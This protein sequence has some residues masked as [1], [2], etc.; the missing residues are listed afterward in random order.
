VA[1]LIQFATV[2]EVC[3]CARAAFHK[4]EANNARQH[5]P[6]KSGTSPRGSDETLGSNSRNEGI[7]KA[8]VT[9][10]AAMSGK[11]RKIK[12]RSDQRR[13]ESRFARPPASSQVCPTTAEK[14]QYEN[15]KNASETLRQRKSNI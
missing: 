6:K 11:Q 10:L 7:T 13:A 4:P 8:K 2:S 14:R 9:T 1:S 5:R 15:K 12:R 3:A